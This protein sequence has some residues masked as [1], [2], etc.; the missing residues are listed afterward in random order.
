MARPFL[1]ASEVTAHRRAGDVA[2]GDPVATA[3][4][5]LRQRLRPGETVYVFGGAMLGIYEVADRPPPTRFP[6]AEHLWKD[7]APVDGAAEMARILAGAPAYVAVAADWAPG[8]PA[9]EPAARPVF[10]ALHA[11]LARDY[12]LEATIAP[13]ISA[14]GGPI[15]PRLTILLFRRV[16]P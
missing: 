6:F 1:A 9:P 7:G 8:R 12:R 5:W 11:A 4:L 3:G 15:G 16:A 2:W 10:A 13:T 14:G